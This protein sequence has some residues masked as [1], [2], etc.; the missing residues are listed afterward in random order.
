[1]NTTRIG[2]ACVL[3]CVLG[4]CAS[5]GGDCANQQC[6]S[7]SSG[8]STGAS[9]GGTTTGGQAGCS[10]IVTG[11]QTGSGS[12]TANAI[13]SGELRFAVSD[14]STFEFA[15]TFTGSSSLTT[16]QYSDAMAAPYNA[17]YN[18][19]ASVYTMCSTTAN[20]GGGSPQGSFNLTISN[21]GASQA[22]GSQT[23]W[24]APQG[25]LVV[26][27]PEQASSGASGTVTVT[28]TL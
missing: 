28:V 21:P 1:M 5:S 8:G 26:T 22:S 13:S 20:C 17:Q 18:A 9:G 27:L 2:L 23:S 7:G 6:T 11:A 4:G 24:L 14:G 15:A 3:A 19:G 16:G 12:C 25:N 10:Y